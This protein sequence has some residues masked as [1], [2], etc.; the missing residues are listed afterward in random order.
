M[1]N[2]RSFCFLAALAALAAIG[3]DLRGAEPASKV[4]YISVD[5]KTLG[6]A[7]NVGIYLPAGY[8]EATDARYPV[9]Y[10]LHGLFGSER[11]WEQ[12][13]TPEHVDALI[14]AGEMPATIVVCPD[15]ENSFYMKFADGSQDW[16]KFI[17]EDLVSA[18][19]AKYRTKADRSQRGIT[20]DS[21]GGL[22]A[23]NLAFRNPTVYGSV[24]AHSAAL[25]PVDPNEASERMKRFGKGLGPIF[26]NPI[27]VEH[28]KAN[29]PVHIAESKDVK[30]LSSLAIYFDCGEADRFGFDHGAN[31]LHQILEKRGVPHEYTLRPGNH[32][33]DYYIRYVD[34]SLRFHAAAFL[35]KPTSKAAAADPNKPNA[36]PEKTE[37]PAQDPVK[38][39]V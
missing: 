12:R 7:V 36:T 9:L 16:E 21:M 5:S 8:A 19:D 18:I 11:K 13:G 20:G 35:G 10:F 17:V 15:G 33:A 26:G 27:D 1:L 34:F 23:I 37:K 2:R 31:L 6:R 29:N 3:A 28:W 38:K 14:Q 24:S 4:E 32:G 30:E 39:D 22:G 25:L